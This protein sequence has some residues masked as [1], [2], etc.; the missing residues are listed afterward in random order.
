MFGGMGALSRKGYIAYVVWG[1][2]LEAKCKRSE[3]LNYLI[4][5]GR[6]LRFAFWKLELDTTYNVYSNESPFKY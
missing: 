4:Y 1:G 5:K 2:G 6:T 3:F